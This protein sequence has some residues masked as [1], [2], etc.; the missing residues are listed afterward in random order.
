MRKI[1]LCD[2]DLLVREFHELDDPHLTMEYR[3]YFLQFAE[4]LCVEEQDTIVFISREQIKLNRASATVRQHGYSHFYYCLRS[5]IKSKIDKISRESIVIIGSKEVDFR[6]AVNTR[7]L[8][9]CPTWLP[10]EDR[11]EYYGVCVDNPE[12]LYLFIR[13]LN[14]H[15]VWYSHLQ[16]DEITQCISLMDAR[17]RYGN[18]QAGERQM[19][20]AFQMLLKNGI[21]RNYYN[22]LF[23]HFLANMTRSELFDDI[24][25]FGVM[26][27]SNCSV[28]PDLF[29]F[30]EQVR[31]IKNKRIPNR[32]LHGPR[33][34]QNILVRYKNKPTMHTGSQTGRVDLGGK[35]EFDTLIINPEFKE[36]INKLRSEN[37][38][39]V[40]I[41]DDYMNFGNGF[42]AVRCLLKYLGANK[43][44]F[45]S[46]GM[47]RSEFHYKDYRINGDV[48]SPGGYT[49]EL[50]DQKVIYNFDINDTAKNEIDNLYRIFNE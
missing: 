11:A 34:L 33:E 6:L 31:F 39:N 5:E 18:M 28:N 7:V 15:D 32:L 19:M 10:L 41:F 13:T 27:S 1:F 9:I 16:V 23:Y 3:N 22:I 24:E 26:P 21:N 40:L 30:M 29:S 20:Q 48:Y 44:I 35:N 49:A 8:F 50:L 36:K 43:I 12:Q 42:N 46:M 17:T 37:R 38:F 14:N 47:F 2:T 4:K 25:L 45:V